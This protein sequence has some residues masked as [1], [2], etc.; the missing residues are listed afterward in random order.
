MP[1]AVLGRLEPPAS[2]EPQR[3]ACVREAAL[4]LRTFAAQGALPPPP[5]EVALYGSSA[6]G[7]HFAGAALDVTALLALRPAEQRAFVCRLAELFAALPGFEA[8]AAP[9][10][11]VPSVRLR[12][13]ESGLLLNLSRGAG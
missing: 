3:A 2:H 6:S 5:P 11:R 7:L 10:A 8:A 1:Q 13:L 12:Q 9:A 4:A